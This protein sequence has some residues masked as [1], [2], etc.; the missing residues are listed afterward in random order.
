M[1]PTNLS[2]VVLSPFDLARASV[3]FWE[4]HNQRLHALRRFSLDQSRELY[5]ALQSA[6]ALAAE[7]LRIARIELE[8]A[9]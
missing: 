3:D 7:R 9:L 4:R 6:H 5:F 2:A 1:T 8:K